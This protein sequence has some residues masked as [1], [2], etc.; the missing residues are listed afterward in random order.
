MSL[1]SRLLGANPSIQVSTLLSGSLST[2]SA[3]SAF[4]PAESFD[5]IATATASGGES[6]FTF[7]SIPSTYKHLQVRYKAQ[8]NTGGAGFMSLRLNGVTTTGNYTTHDLY[9]TGSAAGG[10]GVT[11]SSYPEARGPQMPANSTANTFGNCVC[12]IHDYSSTTKNKT[13]RWFGGWDNNGSGHISLV[14]NVFLSTAAVSSLTIYF[15]GDAV[16]AGSTFALYGIR[17]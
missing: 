10:G 4:V 16:S 6:S 14:S 3:K 8:R 15:A 17:G 7:S 12:D 5:S 9:G 2:P 13:I 11:S 1:P